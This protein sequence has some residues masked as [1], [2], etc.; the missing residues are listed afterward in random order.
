MSVLRPRPPTDP[1]E[2]H[3]PPGV[4]LAKGGIDARWGSWLA[5]VEGVRSTVAS[6]AGTATEA[7]LRAYGT[8]GSQACR[9]DST[10]FGIL[11]VARRVR[12]SVDRVVVIGD[13]A[14]RALVDLL[15][16]TCCHP[17]H[18]DLPR[19]ER[20]GR[21]RI[22][23]L[24]SGDDDDSVQGLLD[25]LRSQTG[26]RLL[27]AW[28][29]VQVGPCREAFTQDC[30]RLFAEGADPTMR[31]G[32]APNVMVAAAVD[33][34]GHIAVTV[35]AMVADA[36]IPSAPPEESASVFT[37]ASLLPAAIAG[38]DVVRL[39][40]GAAAMARRFR[41]APAESNPVVSLAIVGRW[42][43]A[44]PA[45]RSGVPRRRLLPPPRW[46]GLA[47]WHSLQGDPPDPHA[48]PAAVEEWF[49]TPITVAECRRAPFATIHRDLPGQTTDPS[50]RRQALPTAADHLFLPRCDEHTLGQL[51]EG[52]RLV[53]AVE[54]CLD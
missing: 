47:E 20:G 28:G 45:P 40:E 23:T 27:D 15:M 37:A 26:D 9:R 14:D 21:P 33:H 50:H 32:A 30:V 48:L 6:A 29:V 22:W 31:Q 8:T 53:A 19:H 46:R 12:E 2:H 10:L 43:A 17:R 7:M 38:I 44:A 24:G 35:P 11:D 52:L 4:K 1:I 25:C 16:S 5:E 39:L 42:L 3:L 41:E 49:A 34:P 13:R 54:T 18:D 36:P 51:L